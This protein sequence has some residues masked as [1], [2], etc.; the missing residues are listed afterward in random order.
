MRKL[1]PLASLRAFEAAARHRS[2]AAAAA[3]LGVTPTAISHQIRLLEAVCGLPLFRRRPR[4]LTLTAAGARLFPVL[5]DGLDAFATAVAGVREEAERRPLRVTTTNAFAGLWLVPRLPLWREA[6]PGVGLAVIG[7]DA[8]L[9]LRAGEADV[10]I[11]YAR[12][13]PA[14]LV[15]HEL[16]RDRFYPMCSPALLEAAPITGPAD[17]VRHTLI[18]FDWPPE[19]T[20]APRWSRWLAAARGIPPPLAGFDHM[21]EL[22]FQEELHA[23]EAVIAGQ[24]IAVV[25]DVLASRELRT[26]RLVKA[27]DLALP[28]FIFYLVHLPE[29]PRRPLIERF[30][31]WLRSAP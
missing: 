8:V 2:F 26:G 11:R 12:S 19:D 28:G 22:S 29:H 25:S 5:R 14:D 10:A 24:G 30:A 17:L 18:H 27:L 20:E 1:P 3:E 15:V 4:P 9:D 6:N 7:T 23:I 21:V 16:F 31:Q 13:P